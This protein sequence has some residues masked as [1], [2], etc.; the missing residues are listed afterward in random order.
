VIAAAV[1]LVIGV[2]F[3]VFSGY[4]GGRTDLA[5]MRLVDILDSVPL[6]FVVIFV[7]SFLRGV[8]GG[9]QAP[10]GQIY[11]FFAT[12]GA[13]T[14]LTMA[15]LVRAQ[16]L[17]LKEQGFMEAARSLGASDRWI[18]RR[19]LLPNLVPVILVA[20]TIT[21][22]RIL[23]FESFLSFLGLGVEAPAVSLGVLAR[24]GMDS[25]TVVEVRPWLIA[26]PA[27]V[28]GLLLFCVNFLGDAI[29]DAFDP[30][31][32][33]PDAGANQA[34]D[35]GTT[36][37]AAAPPIESAPASPPLLTI[38]NLEVEFATSAGKVFAVRSASFALW[39]G[40]T[41][42]IVGESGSGKSATLL[43][44]LG[45]LPAGAKVK[46]AEV[47][48][49]ATNLLSLDA[50]GRRKIL[51][52]RIA[53]IPQDPMGSL[54]PHLSVGYQVAEVIRAHRRVGRA[55]ARARV[56]ELF[57]E[58]QIPD[59]ARRVDAK[60]HELSGGLNQRVLIAMAL[61]LEP[62]IIFADEPTTALDVTV[63]AEILRL[64][65]RIVVARRMALVIVS[66]D[67]GVVA[68]LA[69]RIVVMDQ[70]VVVE[71]ASASQVLL[72]P[73]SARTRSILG[74]RKAWE[75]RASGPIA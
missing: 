14:W 4:K 6:V 30:R 65:R 41:L 70:G 48:F 27:I 20:L 75:E 7:Q 15:R 71:H 57:E 49:G 37:P 29:R 33:V 11:I 42:A 74:A 59:A 12:L 16:T 36:I 44:I 5:A 10:G 56:V 23:L 22:P 45:L 9:D 31:S 18:I 58:L 51:G 55:A 67:L 35:S 21:I 2:S 1:S 50:R 68:G 60:P 34:V 3:G 69:D 62:E 63:Q 40:E 39:S 61:A 52:S 13:V 32:T 53:L 24:A 8:R 66:H 43:G 17:A 73:E 46:A 26:T 25:V 54:A 28:L 47:R 72:R 38:R 19:H 64:L